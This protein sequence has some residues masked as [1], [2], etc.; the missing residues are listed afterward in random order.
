M[1]IRIIR[2]RR[3]IP[4]ENRR[5]SIHYLAG[6]ELTVKR[7]WAEILIANGDA[8]EIPPTARKPHP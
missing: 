6:L 4:P 1:R 5:I 8:I 2:E 7:A 3:F